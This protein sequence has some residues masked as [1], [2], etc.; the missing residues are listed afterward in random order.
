MVANGDIANASAIAD[1]CRGFIVDVSEL[2]VDLIARKVVAVE[3]R[4]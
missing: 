1:D 3:W 4:L 2:T